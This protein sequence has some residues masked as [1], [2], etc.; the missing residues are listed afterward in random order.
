MNP[1]EQLFEW[2]LAVTLRASILALIILA[3]QMLFYRWLPA[4]LRYILWLPMILVMILPALPVM[5]FGLFPEKPETPVVALTNPAEGGSDRRDEDKLTTAISISRTTSTNP[6]ALG[7]LVGTC[8]VAFVGLVG[9]RRNMRQ[10][11]SVAVPPGDML[12]RMIEI[13]GREAGLKSNPR[14][15][16]SAKVGSPAVAGIVRPK[17]LLPEGFHDGFNTSEARLILLHEF[18]HMKRHDLLVNWLCCTLQALHWFNP[19]LWFAFSR[20]RADR[21]AACDARVLAIDPTDR[22]AEYGS[23]LL[24]LHETLNPLGLTLGFVGIFGRNAGLKSRIKQISKHRRTSAIARVSSLGIVAMLV[25]FGATKAQESNKSEI[26]PV[27]KSIEAK[28]DTIIIPRLEVENAEL[29]E[30]VDF[31][32]IR[33]IQLDPEKDPALK[34]INI[35]ILMPQVDGESSFKP[36]PITLQRKDATLR[37]LFQEIGKQSGMEIKVEET[38]LTVFPSGVTLPLK[39]ALAKPKP[40]GKAADFAAKIIIPKIDFTNVSLRDAVD[41][42]NREVRRISKDNDAPPIILD[43][44]ADPDS[45]IRELRLT[46]APLPIVL[47]YITEPIK[48]SWATDDRGIR[49]LSE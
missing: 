18:T 47:R 16:M 44:K 26:T 48:H 39:E 45:R 32:R 28:L 1:L 12:L 23:T 42:L 27:A 46:N 43:A 35:V 5:P 49:V 8:V 33:S 36:K 25:V 2:L 40:S 15:L 11:E 9:Y 13:V 7:W 41:F 6:L 24:K 19:I 29:P 3:I 21:E 37:D 31:L 38:A 14:V 34:G 22:R 4:Q 17:L 10:I 30:V 20:M